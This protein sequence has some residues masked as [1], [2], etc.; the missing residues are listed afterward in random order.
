MSY[1]TDRMSDGE[2]QVFISSKMRRN[3]LRA[4]REAAVAAVNEYPGLKAWHWETCGFAAPYPPM[5]IC[6]Q[7]VRESHMLVLL[8]SKDITD[9]TAQEHELAVSL[10]IPDLIFIKDGGL[11]KETRAYV[12][13]RQAAFLTFHST[14]ELKTLVTR[15]L[16]KEITRGYLRGRELQIGTGVSYSAGSSRRTN[17]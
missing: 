11:G 17:G 8:L 12:A 9:N 14:S 4:E 16:I 13:K 10:R 15:S 7:A 3:A 6:L 1:N 2:L 5:D